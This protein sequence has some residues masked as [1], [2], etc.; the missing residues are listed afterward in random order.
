MHDSAVYVDWVFSTI[1]AFQ[2]SAGFCCGCRWSGST[3]DSRALWLPRIRSFFMTGTA[4]AWWMSPR[5]ER[6]RERVFSVVRF[7]SY[8]EFLCPLVWDIFGLGYVT[9]WITIGY[10]WLVE[11]K[12]IHSYSFKVYEVSIPLSY[13]IVGS[14]TWTFGQTLL[15]GVEI[16]MHNSHQPATWWF[17]FFDFWL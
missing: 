17:S 12:Q 1:L 13:A 2:S 5:I 15:F 10:N 9:H 11:R 7:G 3:A 6:E 4:T 16:L 14:D 8:P